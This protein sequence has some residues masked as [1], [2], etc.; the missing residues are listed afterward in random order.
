[1]I[2]MRYFLISNKL[3]EQI[4]SVEFSLQKKYFTER[5]I[6]CY[7]RQLLGKVLK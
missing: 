4:S 1:M 7:T 6:N 2:E 5:E 3:K